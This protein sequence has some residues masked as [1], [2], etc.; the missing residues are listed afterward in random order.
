MRFKPLG[1]LAV[2]AVVPFAPFAFPLLLLLLLPEFVE[3]F[4]CDWGCA[5]LL[6]PEQGFPSFTKT[7]TA[8]RLGELAD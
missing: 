2:A 5:A 1:T 4:V 8:T 7:G 3:L 6:A